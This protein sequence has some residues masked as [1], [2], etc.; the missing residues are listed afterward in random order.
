MQI[1]DVTIKSE[2]SLY[3]VKVNAINEYEAVEYVI[4]DVLKNKIDSVNEINASI[5]T[6]YTHSTNGI[7][8]DKLINESTI[9]LSNLFIKFDGKYYQVF[10]KRFGTFISMGSRFNDHHNANL[11]KNCIDKDHVINKIKSC[12]SG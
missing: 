11:F 12:I 1:F 10:Y 4:Q 5:N 6:L 3:T 9:N 7:D 2:Q 8:V